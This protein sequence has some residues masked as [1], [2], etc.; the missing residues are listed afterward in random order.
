MRY[1]TLASF[2]A[3]I[4][5]VFMLTMGVLVL[6][7]LADVFY[8][9]FLAL[10]LALT[11]G[12]GVLLVLFVTVM[13]CCGTRRSHMGLTQRR[14]ITVFFLAA[15]VGVLSG[16]IVFWAYQSTFGTS[17][18]RDMIGFLAFIQVKYA[19]VVFVAP[20]AFTVYAGLLAWASLVEPRLEFPRAG[21]SVE[22][23]RM[24]G[25]PGGRA[26]SGSGLVF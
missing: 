22:L 5:V 16:L 21:A 17:G 14:D 24:A 3:V 20:L 10:A 23:K 8:L 12:G 19:E 6:V 13:C 15:L 4:L 26:M 9:N 11:I 1:L 25:A 2:M 7:Q 18:D